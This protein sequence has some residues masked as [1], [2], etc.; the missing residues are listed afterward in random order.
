[1]DFATHFE[2]L[3]SVAKLSLSPPL[4]VA[5]LVLPSFV[6]YPRFLTDADPLAYV[7]RQSP[8]R[9]PCRPLPDVH[10]CLIAAHSYGHDEEASAWNFPLTQITIYFFGL[11]G[12]YDP[13]SGRRRYALIAANHG[14]MEKRLCQSLSDTDSQGVNAGCEGFI[15]YLTRAR[16]RQMP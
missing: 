5:L 15:P 3:S 11:R 8:L 12:D 6:S 13:H 4:P 7:Q 16:P 1:M 14:D 2:C 10:L 9:T